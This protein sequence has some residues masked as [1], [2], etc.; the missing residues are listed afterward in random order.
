MSHHHP[1][2]GPVSGHEFDALMAEVMAQADRFGHRQHVHLTWLAVR[3]YGTAGAITMVSEG[4]QRT[5]RYLGAP[6]K[7]HAT[8]SRAWVE[9]V[10][11]HAAAG[12]EAD[13]D[14]FAERYPALLDKRLLARHYRS[15]TLAATQARSAW[16][17]PDLLP[18]PTRGGNQPKPDR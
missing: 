15:S 6:Q 14:T 3:H 12:G 13:F 1:A 16:V 4:I 7:Y 5:A 18:L 9:L 8:V 2:A 10:G 11:Y 17:E